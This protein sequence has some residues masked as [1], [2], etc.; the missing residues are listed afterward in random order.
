MHAWV[1]WLSTWGLGVAAVTIALSAAFGVPY[2][3][4]TA[5]FAGWAFL[6]H[7]VTLDDDLPGGFLA[8]PNQWVARR[9]GAQAAGPGRA[10]RGDRGVSDPA[11][12][13]VGLATPPLR[14]RS[15]S[16]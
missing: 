7:L 12:P 2:A 16:R 13:R 5:G 9:A 4:T 15:W 6:G 10:S 1:R 14:W 8:S 3:Y 11:Q